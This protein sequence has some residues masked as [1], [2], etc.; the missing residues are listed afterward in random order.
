MP[1]PRSPSQTVKVWHIYKQLNFILNNIFNL[2][3]VEA[4]F[5]L[6]ITNSAVEQDTAFMACV[7][8]TTEAG[9]TLDMNISVELN[10]T[11]SSGEV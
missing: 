9:V 2:I 4:T 1:T 7:M 3:F 6:P 5:S 8:L 11:D 10:T